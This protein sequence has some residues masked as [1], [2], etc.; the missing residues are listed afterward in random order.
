MDWNDI[1]LIAEIGRTGSFT[2]AAQLLGISKPTVSRRVAFLEQTAKARI[3]NRGPHGASLTSA[4]EQLVRRAA[5]MREAAADFEKLLRSMGAGSRP[6]ITARMTDGVAS[7]LVTPMLSGL[8]LGPLGLAA[9]R[10]R[11]RPPPMRLLPADATEP[12]DISLIWKSSDDPPKGAPNDI[13][14]KLAD[15]RFVP[16]HSKKYGERQRAI[17]KFANLSDHRLITMHAYGWLFD[18]G[19]EEWNDLL[20]LRATDVI[21]VDSSAAIGLMVCGGAGIGLLP[22][23]AQLFSDDM[24]MT[25]IAM[26]AMF[27]RLWMTCSEEAYKD[28]AIRDCFGTLRKLFQEADWMDGPG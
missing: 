15:L 2:A 28:L 16:F 9:E 17:D 26:P 1:R 6:L 18:D 20:S 27:G 21:S 24:T 4:G 25:D 14:C 12:S 22:T 10:L 3:F 5:P 19:W 23:Y 11:S 13:V 8:S 7:Y